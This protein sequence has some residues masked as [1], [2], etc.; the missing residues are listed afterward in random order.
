MTAKADKRTCRQETRV[1]T[2]TS[3]AERSTKGAL[4]SCQLW[5]LP[6]TDHLRKIAA[7]R[8][9]QRFKTTKSRALQADLVHAHKRRGFVIPWF[10]D[11]RFHRSQQPILGRH[12]LAR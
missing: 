3:D 6:S 12:D 7:N 2:P 11:H 1:F 9:K 4:A 10:L 5:G 8:S